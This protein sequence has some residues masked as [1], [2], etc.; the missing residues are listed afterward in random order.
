MELLTNSSRACYQECPRKYLYS[1]QQQ[2]KPVRDGAA[3]AF[4]KAFHTV[5]ELHYRG[6]T[7][8]AI[9][10]AIIDMKLDPYDRARIEELYNGY[11]KKWPRMEVAENG[12]ER[13]YKFPLLNPATK[14]ASKSF[15][16]AGKIDLIVKDGDGF[17]VCEHKTTSD[18][19][20]DPGCDYWARLSID[21]QISGY[22]MA[23]EFLG[24]KPN[25]IIY[26]VIAKPTIK[27]LKATPAEKRTYKKD[28]TLYANQRATDETPEEFQQRLREEIQSNPDRYF[29]RRDIARLEEQLLEYM[30]DMWSVAKLIIESRNEN[31]WPKRISQCFSYGRCPYY[32][33]CA[34]IASL[35]DESMYTKDKGANPELSQET[36]YHG[37]F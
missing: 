1:F 20:Q 16:L 26:D 15:E 33:V 6:N 2:Y 29:Q 4:G 23:A 19:I 17:A 5:L 9:Q 22:F 7:N 31:Y 10:E 14:G 32:E 11:A 36:S 25:K 8:E 3:L 18:N 12:V 34:K 24:F 35:D 28:G 13:E 30:Q 21:P 27:P 37:A